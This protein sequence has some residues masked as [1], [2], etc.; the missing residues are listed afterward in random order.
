[1]KGKAVKAPKNLSKE[2]KKLWESVVNEYAFED[3]AG[4]AILTTACE[5]FDRMK[6]A[7]SIIKKYG[8]LLKDR[9]GQARTNPATVTERD[10]RSAFLQAMKQLNLDIESLQP[11]GRPPGSGRV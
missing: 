7:Q 9:F 6:E 3:S 4:L 8:I 2:A 11:V 1:M 5:S 10:S